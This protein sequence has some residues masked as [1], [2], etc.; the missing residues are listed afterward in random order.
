MIGYMYTYIIVL[1]CAYQCLAPPY[2]V[3]ADVGY[4]W[5]FDYLIKM[6]PPLGPTLTIKS[7]PFQVFK[8]ELS[9]SYHCIVLNVKL[10]M[11]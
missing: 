11:I 4:R 9:I 7:P 2:L 6:S 10:C 8:L 5:V 1:L 3:G